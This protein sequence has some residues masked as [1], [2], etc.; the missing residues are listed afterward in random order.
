MNVFNSIDDIDYNPET[1]LTLGTFDGVHKGHRYII[2]RLLELAKTG[3]YRDFLITIDPH[4][5]I[6]L[7]KEG[8]NPVRLLT[9]IDERLA[10]FDK[11]GLSNVL[12]LPFTYQFSQTN[13][14]DFIENYLYKKINE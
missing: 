2:T 1:I 7:Q 4:P 13:P 10:L 11:F 9:T 8:K 14:T 6:V 3:N 12:I 5:Q